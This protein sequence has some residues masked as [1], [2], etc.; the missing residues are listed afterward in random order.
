VPIGDSR[1]KW[2]QTFVRNAEIGTADIRYA[3]VLFLMDFGGAA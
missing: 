2:K 3:L 1:G